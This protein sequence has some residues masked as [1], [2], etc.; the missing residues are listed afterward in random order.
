[1]YQWY[2]SQ[3]GRM[4]GKQDGNVYDWRGRVYPFVQV[5]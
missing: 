4:L 5:L 2:V 1:M 3:P